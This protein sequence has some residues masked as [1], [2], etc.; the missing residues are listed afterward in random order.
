MITLN[1]DLLTIMGLLGGII[2]MALT[3]LD[4]VIKFHDR[5]REGREDSPRKEPSSRERREEPEPKESAPAPTARKPNWNLRPAFPFLP[6][7]ELLIIVSTGVLLNYLGLMLSIGLHSILYLDMTGTALAAFLLGPWWGA[8]TALLS[9]SLVNWLF[10]P[11]EGAD[12]R[13][14]PWVLV[15]MTG[16]LLWGYLARGAGFRKYLCNA[17]TSSISHLWFL[18]LFG[19]LGASAMSI[20]GALLHITL[21]EHQALALDQEVRTI[22]ERMITQWQL[23]MEGYLNPLIGTSEASAAVSAVLTILEHFFRYIPDKTVSVS[24]ALI[25]VKYAFPLFEQELI[26]G[27]PDKDYV[28][29]NHTSPLMLGALY[30]PVFLV[31]L[32]TDLYDFPNSWALWS[33]PWV[34]ILGGYAFLKTFGASDTEVYDAA[35][36][37]SARYG[38]ALK[39]VE[40][41]P[42]YNFCRRLTFA[43]LVA[44]STFVLCLPLVLR[45]FSDIALNFLCVVY[46]FLLAVHVVHVAIAQNISV[47]RADG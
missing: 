6:Y 11:G 8:I 24:I 34:V 10:Y 13:I 44:S 33:A 25:V 23:G 15:N 46:G 35:M 3:I 41:E 7:R 18:A 40:R 30:T 42:A 45:N 43:T 36:T 9:N 21:A 20:P 5:F 32:T 12:I 26:H 29:D 27:G 31:F 17:H 47:A 14:F 38:Q 2:V 39:P 37:R 4:Y 19:I 22:L 28:R 16:G 1:N